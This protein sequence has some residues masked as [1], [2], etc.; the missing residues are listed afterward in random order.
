MMGETKM[1]QG[2]VYQTGDG[3]EVADLRQARIVELPVYDQV[4]DGYW[5]TVRFLDTGDIGRVFKPAAPT[6]WRVHHPED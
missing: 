4:R 2:H 3:I 6:H 1:L 5:M